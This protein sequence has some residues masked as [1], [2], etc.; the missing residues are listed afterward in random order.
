M[1]SDQLSNVNGQMATMTQRAAT[2]RDHLFSPAIKDRLAQNVPQWLNPDTLINVIYAEAR[3]TPRILEC[4]I[5]SILQC[6]IQCAQ[7][8]LVPQFGRA[9]LVPYNNS[10]QINGRWTKVMELSFQPGYLGLIDLAR[11]SNKILNIYGAVVHEGDE[12]EYSLGSERKLVHRPKLR[13]DAGSVF[14]V[15]AYWEFKD[16]GQHI[17]VMR[18]DDVYKRRAKSQ[19][20]QYA[21]NNPTNK[22]AQDCPWIV[23]PD[24]MAVKTILKH[25]AK[26][27][28]FEIERFDTAIQ[29]D[30]A[31]ESGERYVD[32]FKSTSA[33]I[34]DKSAADYARDFDYL[35]D[36]EISGEQRPAFNAYLSEVVKGDG[37]GEMVVK[38]EIMSAQDWPAFLKAFRDVVPAPSG[39]SGGSPGGYQPRRGT[40]NPAYNGPP[41]G[42]RMDGKPKVPQADPWERSKWIG[43]RAG[44]LDNK[45]G[46][47]SYV[48]E[49]RKAIG[50]MPM[51]LFDELTDKFKGLY[52]RPFPY[53]PDGE[54]DGDDQGDP[55]GDPGAQAGA[56]TVD[57]TPELAQELTRLNA[58]GN[59]FPQA[60]NKVVGDRT[61][62]TVEEAQA[63]IDKIEQRAEFTGEPPSTF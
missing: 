17:D 19:A 5:E 33:Q 32:P 25:S 23:Y 43:L 2:L 13:G 28:P 47:W 38:A 35:A 40:G 36:K 16:G 34:P 55:G 1:T 59:R 15:Y 24:E 52:K 60:F 4:S 7:A 49:N 27:V 11:R 39:A 42:V 61:P 21:I 26:M 45:T 50:A 22:T 44:S 56:E 30:D 14:A 51:D 3:R 57:A 20:Y 53:N 6:V 54:I 31:A 18:I 46:L 8:G 48:L 63:M 62:E 58:I 37:R 12:F 9:Y 10:K 41:E 29:M